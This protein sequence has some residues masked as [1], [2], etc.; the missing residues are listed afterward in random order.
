LLTVCSTL[1]DVFATGVYRLVSGVSR[2]QVLAS[3]VTEW[4][5]TTH[6]G[7]ITV[8]LVQPTVSGIIG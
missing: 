7:L 1:P 5:K 8:Y 2:V 4:M 3:N 6:I